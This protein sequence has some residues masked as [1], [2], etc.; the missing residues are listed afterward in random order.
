MVAPGYQQQ[1]PRKVGMLSFY[2]RVVVRPHLRQVLLIFSLMIVGAL[3]EM[4]TVGLAVPLLD[5]VTQSERASGNRVL[6]WAQQFLKWGGFSP[7]NNL[8]IASMLA[9]ASLLFLIR[10]GFTLLQEYLTAVAAHRLRRETRSA[11]LERFLY[12][13]YEDL[14][15]RGRGAILH[16]INGPSNAVYSTI[17]ELGRLVAGALNSVVLLLLM[18]YLS[19]WATL[20]IGFIVVCVVQGLR[21]VMDL[22]SRISGQAL[23]ELQAE[24]SKLEVDAIDGL[25]VV[26]GYGLQDRL[27]QKQRSLLT[28]EIRPTLQLVLFQR[29]PFFLNEMTACFIVL[30]LGS[31]AFLW[32]SAGMNFSTL[33]VFLVA[34]R[35]ASPAIASVNTTLVDLNKSRRGVEVIDEVLYLTPPEGE[36]RKTVSRVKEIRL[37]DL[38]F[39]YSARPEHWVLQNIDLSM[40]RGTVTA[41]VGSTGAGKST[42]A[43]LLIGLY[44]PATGQILVNGTD[45]GELKLQTWRKSVGYV[46]QDTFLFNATL[47]ENITLWDP[48]V[49]QDDI[50]WSARVAQLHDFVVTLPDGYETVVGDRGL[51]LS[52]GQCQRVAIA[53]A[54]L[55]RPEVLIFDEATSALDNLTERAVYEAISVLHSDAIVLVIAHRLS[56]VRESD[57]IAVLQSGGIIESGT[58]DSL[59]QEGGVYS[60]LYQTDIFENLESTS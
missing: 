30:V 56:T 31:I 18:F 10:G 36:G 50:E 11:L 52:G 32:P 41:I 25:K 55:R 34:I 53:R 57:Q 51:R 37:K 42:L 26:K 8:V 40:K 12:A 2:W 22:R 29:T 58:H 3:L 45:L 13:R 43:N 6:I 21:R 20:L 49:S 14:S 35:R 39:S 48:D 27:V 9:A 33:V 59:I 47:R 44:R 38:S 28:A 54:I 24:Q 7:S 46:S 16:D 19:W 60:K 4:V 23:Y 1:S 17:I 5:A 15:R